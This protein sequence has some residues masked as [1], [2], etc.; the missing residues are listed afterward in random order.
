MEYFSILNLKREPFSN[1]PDPAYFFQSHQHLGCL[2]KLELSVR[3]RR[4][5]NVV[6]GDVGTGK[7]TLCREL[8]RRFDDDPSCETYLILDPYFSTPVEFLTTVAKMLAVEGAFSDPNQ[9]QIKEAIKQRI[10]Q[11]GVDEEKTIVL[12][13]DEGQ[14]I[15]EFC[16]EILREFL[17][18]ETNENKLLQIVIFAQKEFEEILRTH[19]N[20]ADRINLHHLLEPLN[21]KDT[22]QMI[23]FRV[24]QSHNGTRKR[25]FFTFPAIWAIYRLTGGYPRKI[26]NLC[27]RVLLAMIIQNRTRAGWRL[28]RSCARRVSE[29]SVVRWRRILTAVFTVMLIASAA[30]GL[31]PERIE[32]LW[33][34]TTEPAKKIQVAIDTDPE[35]VVRKPD[36]T[37]RMDGREKSDLPGESHSSGI[38]KSV[39]LTPEAKPVQAARVNPESAPI[40]SAS[41]APLP[42][43][44]NAPELSSTAVVFPEL[45]GK[46]VLKPNETLWRLIEK[47]YGIYDDKY[48]RAIKRANPSIRNPKRI[49]AG[50]IIAVPAVAANVQRMAGDTC[51]IRIDEE[52]RLDE[53]VQA[54]RD[55]PE[56]APPARLLPY[57]K[58]GGFKFA[59]LLQERF[60]DDQA[61]RDRIKSLPGNIAAGA[62]VV[63]F[64]DTKTVF[65][66]DPYRRVRR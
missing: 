62:T 37:V 46:V 15:P 59:I 3:L 20:V 29:A 13:I 63:S 51:W 42:E 16:L 34:F 43:P 11:K 23:L 27:H 2:Q 9:W 33:R 19:A 61:A 32:S 8:I 10:F 4:G 7:T 39:R 38:K 45:L 47:V 22:R 5:L 18:F 31:A 60:G 66:A 54:L 44:G 25:S 28:V 57:W 30:I 26:V 65:F 64:S 35:R 55:Y 24:A 1:S 53:A 17:N 21:F 41:V 6:I 50:R 49:E 36:V 56:S 12:I 40:K 58:P 48:F 14:K 52:N